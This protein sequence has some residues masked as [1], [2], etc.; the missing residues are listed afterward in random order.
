MDLA[1]AMV[2]AVVLLAEVLLAAVCVSFALRRAA[3]P[4]DTAAALAYALV[5]VVAGVVVVVIAPVP[6]AGYLLAAIL[7]VSGLAFRDRLREIG[8]LLRQRVTALLG[9]TILFWVAQEALIVCHGRAFYL[10]DW[11]AHFHAASVVT[12]W[13]QRDF[14]PVMPGR[15]TWL[16]VWAAPALMW[17]PTYATFQLA[18]VVAHSLA[19]P[20]V[21]LWGRRVGDAADGERAW[22]VA[23]VCAGLTFGALYTWPKVLAGQLVLLALYLYTRSVEASGRD[24]R[25]LYDLLAGL[26]W[27]AAFQAHQYAGGYAVAFLAA[28]WLLPRRYPWATVIVLALLTGGWWWAMVTR[29]PVDAWSTPYFN[30]NE[31]TFGRQVALLADHLRCT[32]VPNWPNVANS[33]RDPDPFLRETTDVLLM[34]VPVIATVALPLGVWVLRWRRADLVALAA[35]LGGGGA[36]LCFLEPSGAGVVQAALVPVL[37]W[38]CAV[39]GAAAAATSGDRW[40]ERSGR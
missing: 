22:L 39:G 4:T 3:L 8:I 26:V 2:V 12:G 15:T 14:S 24:E 17:L 7:L 29:F 10:W 40:R 33:I 36:T 38:L 18:T 16:G 1:Q 27:A 9:L 19:F 23:L 5:P 34:T 37:L 28:A 11:H 6:M 20:V 25:V 21:Y 32:I 35:L 13:M 30:A 31:L